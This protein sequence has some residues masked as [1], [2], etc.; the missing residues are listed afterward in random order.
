MSREH[1]TAEEAVSHAALVETVKRLSEKVDKNDAWTR[2]TFEKIVSGN[3][4]EKAKKIDRPASKQII[5]DICNGYE[6]PLLEGGDPDL[7]LQLE[8]VQA[9]ITQI[10]EQ[11]RQ[12]P[13]EAGSSYDNLLDA[14]RMKMYVLD[15]NLEFFDIN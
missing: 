6:S 5:T 3:E 2:A 7:Q 15:N 1:Q 10:R 12:H 9:D 11:H 14:I 4:S 8:A 13:E